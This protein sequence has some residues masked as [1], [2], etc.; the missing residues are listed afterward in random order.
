MALNYNTLGILLLSASCVICISSTV[1]CWYQYYWAGLLFAGAVMCCPYLLILFFVFSLIA[2]LAFVLKRKDYV[3]CWLFV[4]LGSFSAFLL[5]CVYLLLQAPLSAYLKVFPLL[6]QDPEHEMVSAFRKT[7]TLFSGA[8]LSSPF[9]IPGMGLAVV[10]TVAA[11]L[12]GKHHA[13]FIGIC[14][15]SAALLIT[16]WKAE[17]ALLNQLMFPLSII[18]LYCVIVSKDRVNEEVFLGLW[19]PGFIYGFCINLGSDQYFFAFSSVS[20]LMSMAS[21]VIACRY[22]K[23]ERMK[24]AETSNNKKEN[25]L[26]IAFS[27][28]MILQICC[29]LSF[30]YEKVYWDRKGIQNQTVFVESGPDRGLL[31]NRDKSEFYER[32]TCDLEE[33]CSKPEVEKILIVS[34]D[35]G[36]YLIAEKEFATY[37]AWLYDVDALDQYYTL[38]PNKKPDAV[39][40]SGSYH[41]QAVPKFVEDGFSVERINEETE[42][43]IL[44][45]AK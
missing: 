44:Y 26:V 19:I 4:T 36:L 24:S 13:G 31:I 12:S 1:K 6:L 14:I 25:R 11:Y 27:L 22:I 35:C 45:P 42:T 2:V 3:C 7:W 9:F 10:I 30:R 5:F 17:K 23:T 16:Y 29:E 40:I 21:I 15:I 43:A 28:L 20:L 8:Y 33:I 18:G 38:F 32:S 41:L 37:S 34:I 39:Y